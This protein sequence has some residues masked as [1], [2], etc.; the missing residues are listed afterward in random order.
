MF[1]RFLT[2]IMTVL[3]LCGC[4]L[5][6]D[7]ANLAVILQEGNEEYEVALEEFVH[8]VDNT[9]IKCSV[10][11]CS[12][13]EKAGELNYAVYDMFVV[14]GSKA[15]LAVQDNV[16]RGIPVAYCM[17]YSPEKVGLTSEPVNF[18]I[19]LRV[20]V[21][22]QIGLVRQVLPYSKTMVTFINQ[23]QFSRQDWPLTE[24]PESPD[25]MTVI[26][27]DEIRNSERAGHVKRLINTSPDVIWTYPD[28]NV[29][30]MI[31]MKMVLLESI[32]RKIPVFG[33]SENVVKA[34]ALMGVTVESRDQGRQLAEMVRAVIAGEELV[35]RHRN[36]SFKPVFNLAVADIIGVE[37]P[38]NILSQA[39]YVYG[40]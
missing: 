12:D 38:E 39:K 20:S 22:D 19:S 28:S 37:I 5:A 30:H 31:T 36:A 32:R 23:T 17:V 16:P 6:A 21:S 14:I 34:G 26:V 35:E 7:S 25:Y 8:Q 9:E 4:V 3:V 13:V 24:W 15:A 1:T 2:T 10:M 18:G 11:T 29:F 27:P 40:R 33:Y